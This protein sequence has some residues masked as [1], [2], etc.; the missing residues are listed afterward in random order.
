M[1]IICKPSV[2][3]TRT[4]HLDQKRDKILTM[5]RNERV[6]NFS[7]KIMLDLLKKIKPQD[8]RTYPSRIDSFYTKL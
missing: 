3:T 4:I 5:D 8:L 1:K 2:V 6:D 7:Q